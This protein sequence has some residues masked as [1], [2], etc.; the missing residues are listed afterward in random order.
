MKLKL[1]TFLPLL[2]IFT[3]ACK[4]ETN[5]SYIEE[6]NEAANVQTQNVS[7]TPICQHDHE[8]DENSHT[9]NMGRQMGQSPHSTHN[10]HSATNA[11]DHA[12]YIWDL[13]EGWSLT[14]K[15]TMIRLA[16]FMI[17]DKPSIKCALYS[18]GNASSGPEEKVQLW[19]AQMG[20][21]DFSQ[22]IVKNFIS[23]SPKFNTKGNL[24]GTYFDF[25]E[26]VEDEKGMLIIV[27]MITTEKN[28]LS[29]KISGEKKS[30]LSC[31]KS[32][33]LLAE[34]IRP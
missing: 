19:A 26:F 17:K 24:S 6:V 33:K 29:L 8:K 18:L 22:K 21:L 1:F 23:S 30:V 27:A 25:S 28:I 10:P 5:T 20:L 13:P 12:K 3:F 11:A 34:S 4:D 31:K 9:V 2:L 32:F 16:T 14:P 7:T 15:K